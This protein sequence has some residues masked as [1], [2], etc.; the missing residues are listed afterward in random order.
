MF[1]LYCDICGE[2]VEY[3]RANFVEFNQDEDLVYHLCPTCFK[4]EKIRYSNYRLVTSNILKT[5]TNKK[6]LELKEKEDE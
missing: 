2:Q 1:R 3:P 5:L 4:N 6:N